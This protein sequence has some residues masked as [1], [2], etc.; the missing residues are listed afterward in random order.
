MAGLENAGLG[1]FCCVS[2][3]IYG[4][5]VMLFVPF[6][7]DFYTMLFKKEMLFSTAIC[8]IQGHN[9]MGIHNTTQDPLSSCMYERDEPKM[10]DVQFFIP[11]VLAKS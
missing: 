6:C 7:S 8:Q 9:M 3:A 1:W 10:T 11:D 4:I 5:L 2:E